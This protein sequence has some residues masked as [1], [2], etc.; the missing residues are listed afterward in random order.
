MQPKT[1]KIIYWL[2]T[3]IFVLFM[4]LDGIGGVMRVEAGKESM[5][6]LGYPV[7]LL[8]ILGIAKLLGA[9]ALLQNKLDTLKEWAYAGFTINLT[10][11]TASHI[12]VGDSVGVIITPV[13]VSAVMFLSY[14]LWRQSR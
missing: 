7:Y 9:V 10:G 6:H 3:I 12:F 4:I 11:A 2:V 13:I 5:A 1:L 14:G 8:T